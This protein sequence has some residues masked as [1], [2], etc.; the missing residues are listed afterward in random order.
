MFDKGRRGAK[1]EEFPVFDGEINGLAEIT[2][3]ASRS[4]QQKYGEVFFSLLP[5]SSK[6]KRKKRKFLRSRDERVETFF[7]Q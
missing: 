5:F 2:N 6:K 3:S 1:G 7:I 4:F